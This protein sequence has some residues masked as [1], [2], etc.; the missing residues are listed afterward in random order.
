MLDSTAKLCLDNPV[1]SINRLHGV[2]NNGNYK[3]F[4]HN[5]VK[6]DINPKDLQNCS[7][8]LKKTSDDAF[9]IL[10]DHPNTCETLM[11]LK[12]IKLIIVA[13]I[14]KKKSVLQNVST[15]NYY[16]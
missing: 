1:I 12:I 8:C 16:I 14:E 10:K 2:M 4:D 11:Y 5:L 7:S 13:Y 6:S 9:S 3:K 15:R